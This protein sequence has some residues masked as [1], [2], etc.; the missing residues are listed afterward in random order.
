MGLGRLRRFKLPIKDE[1]CKAVWL[2]VTPEEDEPSKSLH[3]DYAQEDYGRRLPHFLAEPEEKSER[4]STTNSLHGNVLFSG[5]LDT[6]VT[7]G[8][9][10]RGLSMKSYPAH[11]PCQALY[12]H[13]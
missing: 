5:G 8:E 12:S 4:L 11:H 9:N 1:V 10:T 3:V 6:A 13:L 2:V 7:A